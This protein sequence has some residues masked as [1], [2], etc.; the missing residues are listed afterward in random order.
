MIASLVFV[1]LTAQAPAS[2]MPAAPAAAA[3]E[4]PAAS[5]RSPLQTRIDAAAPGSVIDV[6]AGTYVGDLV[7]DRPVRLVGHG[8]PL[9]VGSGKGSVVRVIAPDVHIEGIDVDGRSGGDVSRD[10]SGIH[11]WAPRAVIEDCHI[12]RALFGI[13]L[14]EANG[15]VVARCTITG[16][17]DLAPGE[18]GS[19]I[20]VFSTD[21]F[22]LDHNTVQ[23]S[24]D[25]IY[26]QASPHGVTVG[27]T[28]RDLRY[29]LHYMFSDDNVFED[30]TFERGA[31]GAALMYSRR[32][33][34]RRNQFLHNRGFASVGL[35][36]QV[37]DDVT[38]EDNL[39]GDNARGLFMEGSHRNVFRRNVIAESDVALVLYDSVR[40]VRFE[41]NSFVGN[42]SPLQLVGRRTDAIFDR[43]YWSDS[44]A[45]DLD[46]DGV[47]DAP[48]RVSSVFDHL[49]GNLT[50]A[51]LY[52]EGIGAAVLARAEEVF[53]VLDPAPVVDAHPLARTPI[54]PAVPVP[55]S[56]HVTHRTWPVAASG[57]FAVLG[58]WLFARNRGRRV[59]S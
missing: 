27:N 10:S 45:A 47:Q 3:E 17:P 2:P 26:I 15:S 31:A 24:R 8:R 6:P 23:Y 21:G 41:D 30:N 29:G 37:C 9:L 13:Y 7:I 33:T 51:D 56:D 18:Q 53:P 44:R 14:R 57:G 40:D 46:G 36:L 25:G 12:T 22:R 28:A 50:A 38:A 4:R 5:D 16:Q 1:V 34:F 43:N 42:L 19:G 48:Y 49:R 59:K 35:L 20:H 55:A 39:I 52:A 58:F 54:L 11:V 32:L